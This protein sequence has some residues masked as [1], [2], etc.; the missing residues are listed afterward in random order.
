[1]TWHSQPLAIKEE[2]LIGVDWASFGTKG[3]NAQLNP[4]ANAETDTA[5]EAWSGRDNFRYPMKLKRLRIDGGRLVRTRGG[6]LNARSL[7][8][9][10]VAERKLHIPTETAVSLIRFHNR[11]APAYLEGKRAHGCKP[12]CRRSAETGGLGQQP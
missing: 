7:F 5:T 3:L 2:K 4:C 11:A 1:M 6:W 8:R 10:R 9:T 12:R